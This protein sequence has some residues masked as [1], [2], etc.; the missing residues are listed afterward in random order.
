MSDIDSMDFGTVSSFNDNSQTIVLV[1]YKDAGD[2]AWQNDTANFDRVPNVGE[3][4][5][6]S[7]DGNWYEVKAV[8][9][10][11]FPLDYDA[12]IYALRVEDKLALRQGFSK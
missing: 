5:A 8:V 1:F 9:H 12:E 10:M 11:G 6:L 4:F 7:R 2:D 3:F